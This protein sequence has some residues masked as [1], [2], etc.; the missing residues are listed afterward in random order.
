MTSQ[1]IAQARRELDQLYRQKDSFRAWITEDESSQGEYDATVAQ[2]EV[3]NPG[4]VVKRV[5]LVYRMGHVLAP[6]DSFYARS[7][8]LSA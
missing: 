1:E 6:E 7:T 4:L 2:L 5:D 8:H 3:A